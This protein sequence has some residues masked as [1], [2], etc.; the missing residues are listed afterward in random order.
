MLRGLTRLDADAINESLASEVMASSLLKRGVEKFC[1]LL[2]AALYT[3]GILLSLGVISGIEETYPGSDPYP[4]LQAEALAE[5]RLALSHKA[6][7]LAFDLAWA[8]GGVQ[9]VWGLG[10]PGWILA[11]S[12]AGGLRDPLLFPS[13]VAFGIAL[14]LVS[15]LLLLV[16]VRVTKA[17]LSTARAWDWQFSTVVVPTVALLWFFPSFTATLKSVFRVYEEVSAYSY[18]C[19]MLL[20]VL[21]VWFCAKPSGTRLGL[22]FVL[23][24]VSPFVRPTMGIYGGAAVLVGTWFAIRTRLPVW[25]LACGAVVYAGL[26][27]LLLWTN[28]VR[29]GAPLEF[30]HSLNVSHHFDSLYSTRF[31]SPYESEPLI[32][33]L[34]EVMGGLLFDAPFNYGGWFQKGV[35]H[36]QSD[37]LRW[38]DNY[39]PAIGWPI[40]GF[41][42]LGSMLAW[43]KVRTEGS[44]TK[45]VVQALIGYSMVAAAGLTLFYLRCPVI[46]SRYYYDFAGAIA[47]AAATAWWCLASRAVTKQML[48]GVVAAIT[49]VCLCG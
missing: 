40:I 23:A 14:L 20:A 5:G 6:D 35:F 7:N 16:V 1:L 17:C 13:R 33:A 2:I 29:F 31:A 24:G 3:V 22:L 9:Q 8:E 41:A 32:P 43:F 37:T 39:L 44:A 45:S 15:W 46:S 11:V 28:A 27:G 36:W 4:G 38:R 21:L 26:I 34:R 47:V 42:A 30:G 25:K 19:A 18:L 49:G 12:V 10:V 48:T